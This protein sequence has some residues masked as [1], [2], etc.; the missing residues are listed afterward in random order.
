MNQD[1]RKKVDK[2]NELEKTFAEKLTENGDKSYNST[3]NNLI[4]LLF[5]ADFFQKNLNQVK[6]GNS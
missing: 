5:M 3:G 6:I 4:D 1:I 2:M